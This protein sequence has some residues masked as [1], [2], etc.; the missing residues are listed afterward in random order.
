MRLIP[1]SADSM[2]LFVMISS[3]GIVI[4]TDANVKNWFIRVSVMMDLI[5]I[6]ASVN[7]NV[8]S[9]LYKF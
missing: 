9:K 1:G 6:L 3:V 4:N 8:I 5:G 2:R 7:V